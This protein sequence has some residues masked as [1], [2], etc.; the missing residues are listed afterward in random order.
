MDRGVRRGRWRG[1]GLGV[2]STADIGCFQETH[3]GLLDLA[4]SPADKHSQ[5]ISSETFPSQF[6]P[7]GPIRLKWYCC[8]LHLSVCPSVCL[9]VC[10]CW[11]ISMT[12]LVLVITRI[13][14]KSFWNFPGIF[15]W[16]IILR[17][18]RW[19]VLQLVKYAHTVEPLW[20]G[21]ESLTKV[22]KLGP[23]P[24]TIIYKSCLFYPSWQATS[25]GLYRGVPL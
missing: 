11:S 14:F 16:W 4:F 24:G 23:F 19:W 12:K 25:C 2:N 5:Q 13:F 22:A 6:L 3:C 15:F 7:L 17:Q 10:D 9:F 18:V 1:E 20:K 21:Q 8:C